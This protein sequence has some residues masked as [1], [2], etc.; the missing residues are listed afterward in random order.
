[1]CPNHVVKTYP[2]VINRTVQEPASAVTFN[3]PVLNSL[4]F[5]NYFL[6]FFDGAVQ[7]SI[8]N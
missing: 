7:S 5:C 8:L 3:P 2:M 6:Y 4:P 1:M